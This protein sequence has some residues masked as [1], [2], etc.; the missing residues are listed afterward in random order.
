MLSSDDT[1]ITAPSPRAVRV[2]LVRTGT[3]VSLHIGKVWGILC[4]A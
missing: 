1:P 4:A 2:V 3:V